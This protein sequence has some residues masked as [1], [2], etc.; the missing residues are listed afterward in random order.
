MNRKHYWGWR[1]LRGPDFAIRWSGAARLCQSSEGWG[2]H[3]DFAKYYLLKNSS[4]KVIE[5]L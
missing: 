2:G 1:L 5:H 3:P 4:N